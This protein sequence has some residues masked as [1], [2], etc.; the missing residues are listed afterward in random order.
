MDKEIE[1]NIP[2]EKIRERG[3][4]SRRKDRRKSPSSPSSSRSR[5]L[6]SSYSSTSSE[7]SESRRK[8]KKSSRRKS[9]RKRDRRERKRKSSRRSRSRSTSSENDSYSSN[10]RKKKKRRKKSKS[11]K[12]SHRKSSKS[13]KADDKE[14]YSARLEYD[15]KTLN[16]SQITQEVNSNDSNNVD[17]T[18]SEI[19]AKSQT[20]NEP[21]SRRMVPMT[22]E[23]YE[24]QQNTVREV[25]DPE[26]G[27]Y[28]LVRGTGEIIERIVSRSDHE[29]INKTATRGD[30]LSFARH[31]GNAARKY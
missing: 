18:K 22:R 23:E 16:E 26:S 31:I 25:F 21:P 2:T 29:R 17:S 9:R 20:K 30:G 13:T 10:D 4:S 24:K 6:S 28:R 19:Q 7:D 14:K 3:R 5:S 8:R 12:K 27:R 11:R 1:S 15:E